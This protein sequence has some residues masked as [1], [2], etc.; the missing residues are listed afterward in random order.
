[1]W[2]GIVID[3]VNHARE[4]FRIG[5]RNGADRHREL[6]PERFRRFVLRPFE[7]LTPA[8]HWP[9][10]FRRQI[11][12]YQRVILLQDRYGS[13]AIAISL[14]KPRDLILKNVRQ[15]LDENERKNII[16]ELRRVLLSANR[17]GAVPK[18]LLHGFGAEHRAFGRAALTPAHE[19]AVCKLL[20]IPK[21]KRFAADFLKQLIERLSRRP[22]RLGFAIFPTIDRRKRN[23]KLLRKL[24][25]AELQFGSQGSNDVGQR[26]RHSRDFV[27]TNIAVDNKAPTRESAGL[28][29]VLTTEN[30]L[31]ITNGAPAALVTPWKKLCYTLCYTLN[32]HFSQCLCGLL[33]RYTFFTP[34][35]RGSLPALL[36]L[37]LIVLDRTRPPPRPRSLCPPRLCAGVNRGS[38]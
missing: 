13:L 24:F 11:K 22:L 12:A 28:A 7:R 9:A 26:V 34:W 23:V 3:N 19:R 15:A 21:H 14:D 10:A 17:A 31:L 35:E 32:A 2:R 8:D 36:I 6:L 1:M 30:G 5:F 38:Y 4:L 33:R 20:N 16:L 29:E 27:I 18:H 37:P 25:L